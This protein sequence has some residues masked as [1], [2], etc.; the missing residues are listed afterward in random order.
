MPLLATAIAH[1]L[2]HGPPHTLLLSPFLSPLLSPPVPPPPPAD[3]DSLLEDELHAPSPT[4]TLAHA[5]FPFCQHCHSILGIPRPSLALRADPLG[6]SSRSSRPRCGCARTRCGQKARGAAARASDRG[7][8]VEEWADSGGGTDPRCRQCGFL[9]A[10]GPDGGLLA[11][12]EAV[13]NTLPASDLL[14]R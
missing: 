6:R 2:A 3:F 7:E 11:D 5:G 12:P 1:S 13:V 10:Q 9:N 14:L 4:D 8:E